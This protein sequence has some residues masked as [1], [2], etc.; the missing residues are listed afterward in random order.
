MRVIFNDEDEP[1]GR[2]IL[3]T[4][5]EVFP[6]TNDPTHLTCILKNGDSWSRPFKDL[7]GIYI[8]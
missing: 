8:R 1:D 4:V 2:L 7:V 5:V 3:K 6:H